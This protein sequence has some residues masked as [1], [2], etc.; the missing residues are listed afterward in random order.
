MVE[1][2]LTSVTLMDDP[3][4]IAECW[5]WHLLSLMEAGFTTEFEA[6]LEKYVDR[7]SGYGLERHGYQAQLLSI[8]LRLLRGEWRDVRVK[9]EDAYQT[10]SRLARRDNQQS[11]DGAYGAQMFFL[12]RELGALEAMRP[13]IGQVIEQSIARPWAPGLVVMCCELGLEEQAGL[14]FDTLAQNEFS[15]LAKDDMWLT[16][17]AFCAEA[18]AYLKDSQRAAVLYELLLPFADQTVNHPT[19]VCFGSASRYLG[20]LAQ[21]LGQND[22][23]QQHYDAAIRLNRMMGAWPALAR[24]QFDLARLLISEKDAELVQSG[25]QLLIEAEQLAARFKMTGLTKAIAECQHTVQRRWPDGL[26]DREVEVL[27]LIAM[28]RSNKDV[29]KVL[30]ISLSTVATHIRSI[31][32]KTGTSNRTE[33]AAYAV[34][35][36]LN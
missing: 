23:A 20:M 36:E 18:C 16:C 6:L 14:T 11:G 15:G 28:G 34:R 8:A 4:E 22:Q 7:S 24:T 5:Y 19:A 9:I 32:S 12:N 30:A 3:E 31:F 10:G 26:T 13:L 35:H 27:R 33:A 2:W 29:S 25:R 21:V 17:V 1:K